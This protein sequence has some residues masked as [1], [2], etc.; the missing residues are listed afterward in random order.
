[1]LAF[2]RFRTKWG[3]S[4]FV[5]AAPSTWNSLPVKFR[6][7]STV[8]SF[9]KNAEDFSFRFGS[10]PPPIPRTFGA[11]LT[12][13]ALTLGIELVSLWILRLRGFR[14]YRSYRIELN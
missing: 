8:T 5:V 11:Q 13:Y 7:A 3:S 9:K 10:P 1:M 12:T 6:T 4:A 2:P 14:R